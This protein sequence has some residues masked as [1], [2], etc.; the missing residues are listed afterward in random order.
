[1]DANGC[2]SREFQ[3]CTGHNWVRRHHLRCPPP[4]SP[5]RSGQVVAGGGNV[6]DLEQVLADAPMLQQKMKPRH[7]TMIAVGGSIG[8][9]LFVGSGSALNRGGPAGVLI[10]WILIGVMLINVTQACLFFRGS[11]GVCAHDDA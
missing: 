5:S 8:T 11:A 2:H 9:G 4:S 10:A 3:A 1:M 7:L 6:A